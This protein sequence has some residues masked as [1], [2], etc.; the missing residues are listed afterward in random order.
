MFKRLKP[1]TVLLSYLLLGNFTYTFADNTEFHFPLSYQWG[2]GLS[3]PAANVNLGGYF[4][5]SYQQPEFIQNKTALDELGFFFTW[6]PHQRIRF[7][8]EI[9]LNDWLST[10]G[11]DKIEHVVRAERLYVDL[12]A[13]ESTTLR[14]GKFLTPVGRWNAT[15]AAPLIWTTTRPLVTERR[16]FTSHA[17][18]FMLS[19]KVDINDHNLDISFYADNSEELDVLDNQL[20]FENA[21]G[22]RVTFDITEQ[23]QLGASFLDYK[24]RSITHK[25]RNNLFGV[26]L[27]WK[28][29]G[30]EVEMEAIY[31]TAQDNQGD[32]Q[33]LYLQSVI[34][35]IEQIFVIGRYEYVNGIHR[36]IPTDTHIG[37]AGIAWRPF[38][39]LVI[40]AEYLFGEQN[41]YVAPSGF[42]TSISMFF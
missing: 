1:L 30:Y 8:S 7:F 25:T 16:L 18:G 19:Q 2:R 31:R 20:G 29:D 4:N 14:L 6:S 13:T 42:F 41:Q 26:D 10:T 15:H 36:Y 40:K 28:K 3:W 11:I 39:P 32:E 33:G 34:P 37:V 12:L 23:L 9:D 35:I 27:L 38:T 24:N 22:S 21:I 17:S 5:A